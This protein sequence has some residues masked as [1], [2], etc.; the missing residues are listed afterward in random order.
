M[1]NLMHV[2]VDWLKIDRSFVAAVHENER[3]QR[4]VRGQIAVASVLHVNL[5]A[6]GV[7]NQAQA[8][9]LLDAGCV[10][11]QRFLCGHPAEVA[12]L[13]NIVEGFPAVGTSSEP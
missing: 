11:H 7:E 3:V 2:P 5:I 13:A 12:D 10:L 1:T 6:E 4:V 8:D 9:W